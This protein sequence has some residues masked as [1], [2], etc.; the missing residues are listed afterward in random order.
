MFKACLLSYD[1]KMKQTCSLRLAKQLLEIG[2]A[3]VVSTLPL[4]VKFK[5]TNDKGDFL[6]EMVISKKPSPFYPLV[7]RKQLPKAQAEKML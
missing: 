1:E 3:E 7:A 5:K 4:V 6:P 2:L